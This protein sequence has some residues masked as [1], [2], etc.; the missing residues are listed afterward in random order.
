MR[1]SGTPSSI[2]TAPILNL[3]AGCES[4]LLK[5]KRESRARITISCK[6]THETCSHYSHR[7]IKTGQDIGIN[8]KF[9][10]AETISE[11]L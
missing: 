1:V 2:L 5:Y 3:L 10:T 8:W 4:E 7:G 6:H 11:D 9:S